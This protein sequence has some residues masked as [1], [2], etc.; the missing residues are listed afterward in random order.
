MKADAASNMPPISVT[1]D[2]RRVSGWLKADAW[3]NMR[4]MLVTLEASRL[5][6]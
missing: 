4:P 6:G 3:E 1:L 2:V 5:N